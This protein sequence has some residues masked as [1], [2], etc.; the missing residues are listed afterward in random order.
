MSFLDQLQSVYS[1]ATIATIIL[2]MTI[3]VIR[4][5]RKTK[6]VRETVLTEISKFKADYEG[7]REHY[8]SQS[9]LKA[10]QKSYAQTYLLAKRQR[11]KQ[12]VEFCETYDSLPK[13]VKQDNVLY[14]RAETQ[15]NAALF[16]DVEGKK[17]DQQQRTAIVTDEDHNLVIAGAGA[18]K[19]LTIAGKV[20]Y[21]CERK[22]VAPEDILLIAFGK[23][24]AD[25]MNGRIAR[26]MGYRVHAVTFHKLGL[27]IIAADHNGKPDVFEDS[28]FSK[29]M[30]EFFK[31]KVLGKPAV[32]RSLIEYFAYY[33]SIPPDMDQF[34]SSGE[35]IEYE[36]N[37]D[38]E[39]IQ[40]KYEK[41]IAAKK[42]AGKA[43]KLTLQGEYVKSVQE[44]EIA[45]YLFLHGVKYE[46]ERVYPFVTADPLHRAYKPDF[47]LPDYDIY[48]EHFGISKD[49]RVPWLDEMGEK[50]YLEDMRWKR[51]THHKNHTEL[52]ETYSWYQ[53]EGILLEKLEET[54]T[55]NGVKLTDRDPA[56]IYSHLYQNIGD[57]Y[58]HEFIDLCETFIQLYKSNGYSA[59]DLDALDYKS[60]EYKTRFHKERLRLFKDII[61]AVMSEYEMELKRTGKIDFSDMINLATK[62][63]RD[64]HRVHPYKYVIVDE[65]QDIAISRSNLL[66]AILE[67]TGAHLLCVGDDWQSIYRFTG[68]D[69]G[70]F[71][72]FEQ[73]YVGTEIMRIERTYRN[74]QQLINSAT[75][76]VTKNPA[77]FKKSLLSAKMKPMP[78]H[79]YMYQKNADSAIKQAVDTIIK[80]YGRDKTILFLGRVNSEYDKLLETNLFS[81]GN[82]T[83]DGTKTLVYR[84]YPYV[85]MEYM[86]IHAS[87]G[88]EKDNVIILNFNNA[89]L[90]IP[91]KISDDPILELVLSTSDT[92]RYGEE[93]RLLYVAMT[94]TKNEVFLITSQSRPSEFLQDFD[95]DQYSEQ[96]PVDY[97]EGKSINCPW[98]KT[99][100]LIERD[101][102]F[103]KF[104][105]CTNYPACEYHVNEVTI[106]TNPIYC[107]KCGGLMAHKQGRFGAFLSCTNF[108]ACRNTVN[109]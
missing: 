15:M 59:G 47:Y 91:N 84:D 70:L 18:G 46:Y 61:N 45:N 79:F 27:D 74:S 88:K 66:D 87:K 11:G 13:T 3:I 83:K 109:L 39:T 58:F 22:H 2:L 17:L 40:S 100:K 64:G 102:K 48:Y 55:R 65:Y 30:D 95:E 54:L 28:E 80:H 6:P 69:I 4:M 99:G 85:P 81:I 10:L 90:G 12:F 25:E 75:T 42:D 103:G 5:Q 43:I 49:N 89:L 44:L 24:A 32:I 60:K 106:L 101:G 105:G 68:S 77:Q 82:K 26:K 97:T 1:V 36:R 34:S 41:A 67:Q 56:D 73:H 62:A 9:Q 38:L 50:R 53:N 21:L 19:T 52:I 35:A 29:F 37:S 78:V 14:V 31:N 51:D 72:G 96:V 8:I 20:K 16:D 23:K 104:V 76:F 108:P 86:T 57:R 94:R 107:S 7:L 33:I 63:V 92:Y 93:R 98:C 71:T